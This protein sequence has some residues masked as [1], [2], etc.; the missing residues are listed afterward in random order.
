MSE[1]LSSGMIHTHRDPHVAQV[2]SSTTPV[3]HNKYSN[4]QLQCFGVTVGIDSLHSQGVSGTHFRD[5]ANDADRIAEFLRHQFSCGDRITSLRNSHATPAAIVDTFERLLDNPIVQKGDY[6]VFYYAGPPFGDLDLAFS[7]RA[8]RED[9]SAKSPD[10]DIH[11][12]TE[13]LLVDVMEKL[14]LLKGCRVWIIADFCRS[15]HFDSN[16]LLDEQWQCFS[17]ETR[18]SDESGGRSLF[19]D[20]APYVVFSAFNEEEELGLKLKSSSSSGCGGHF[21][22]ALLKTIR[23]GSLPT[24]TFMGLLNQLLVTLANNMDPAQPTN[25][26]TSS[27]PACIGSM[28]NQIIFARGRSP[29]FP[30]QYFDAEEGMWMLKA[31]SHSGVTT[32]S[33]W[34]IFAVVTTIQSPVAIGTSIAKEPGRDATRLQP[35][36]KHEMKKLIGTLQDSC[37]DVSVYAVPVEG[38]SSHPLRVYIETK[39]LL[40]ISDIPSLYSQQHSD[41]T[42]P[43]THYVTQSIPEDADLIVR[44]QT[45]NPDSDL[46]YLPVPGSWEGLELQTEAAFYLQTPQ[47][48]AFHRGQPL[49]C[50]IAPVYDIATALRAAAWWNWHLN[51]INTPTL[52]QTKISLQLLK[53]GEWKGSALLRCSATPLPMTETGIIQLL[54]RPQDRYGIKI[55]NNAKT[56]LYAWAFYFSANDLSID[57]LFNPVPPSPNVP[58]GG[59]ITIGDNI[60]PQGKIGFALE[61]DR[62]MDIGFIKLFWFTE[63]LDMGEVAQPA[64]C[65]ETYCQVSPKTVTSIEKCLHNCSEWGAI[66]ITVVQTL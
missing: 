31:G 23:L 42:E 5:A 15:G 3:K 45:H 21:T 51:C 33:V 60:S 4:S 34:E 18:L 26:R 11:G 13:T 46:E 50:G 61:H 9:G 49:L 52:L 22:D 47:V 57:K 16:T 14:A 64:P 27:I 29:A 8:E 37:K 12:V 58:P 6:I 25:P 40:M 24:T 54:V 41:N 62:N 44:C 59:S 43:S 17:S 1:S 20:S 36:S 7:N 48:L 65:C 32:N 39:K 63:Y 2:Y 38:A 55:I 28:K 66:T 10:N 19:Q 35:R 53:L 30:V 56:P